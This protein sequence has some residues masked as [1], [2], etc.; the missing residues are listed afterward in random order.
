[1]K[2]LSK[3]LVMAGTTT[4]TA[5]VS[6]AR[7]GPRSRAAASPTIPPATVVTTIAATTETSSVHC[8]CPASRS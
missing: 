4:A 2:V 3:V 7:Y 5:R 8:P 6:P 1:M